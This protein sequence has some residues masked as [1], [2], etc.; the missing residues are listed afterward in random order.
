MWRVIGTSVVGASHEKRHTPCQDYCG[1]Q[2]CQLGSERALV[3]AIADGAGSAK[4]SEIGSEEAVKHLLGR[5]GNCELTLI[6]IQ[7]E[8]AAGWVQNVRDHLDD[9]AV[10]RDLT[11]RDLACTLLFAILTE[12]CAV[13]C[14]VGDGGW[15]VKSNG[16]Y[17]TA[18]WPSGGEYANQTT[19]ITSPNWRAVLQFNVLPKSLSAVAGFS[20][21]L[22]NVA[23]HFASRSVHAPFFDSKF[24]ALEATDDETSLRAPLMEFLSSPALAER[25]DDDKTLV[26]ACRQE[27]KLLG[28]SAS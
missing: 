17:E 8:V 18:T 10:A 3:I 2:F 1:Y 20:D 15:V 7:E 28:D 4:A 13:F 6:E 26:L 25:T 11:T 9:I 21:G 5:I 23:L 19:F 24:E 16:S 22:Q 27:V 14:Q 12:S